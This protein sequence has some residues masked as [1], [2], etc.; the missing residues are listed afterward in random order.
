MFDYQSGK[1]MMQSTLN[2]NRF[3]NQN[4][5]PGAANRNNGRLKCEGRK[6][7]VQR[8]VILVDKK[9]RRLIT[10]VLRTAIIRIQL[11]KQS[12]LYQLL[13]YKINPFFNRNIGKHLYIIF[14]IF[15]N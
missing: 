8:T 6:A 9:I 11:L 12:T 5:T 13:N 15:I 1:H 4:Y 7:K 14:Q 3:K 10:K 2:K